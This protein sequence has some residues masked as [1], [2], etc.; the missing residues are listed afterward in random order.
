MA[1][2]WTIVGP[3]NRHPNKEKYY[4]KVHLIYVYIVN[5]VSQF[6]SFCYGKKVAS[7]CHGASAPLTSKQP[8]NIFVGAIPDF[9]RHTSVVEGRK[10]V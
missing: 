9:F 5:I 10:D 4:L 2:D 8:V 7:L 6:Q 3:F 1:G